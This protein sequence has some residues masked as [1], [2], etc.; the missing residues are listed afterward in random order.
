MPL[1]GNKVAEQDLRTWLQAHGWYGR[2]A[3]I[4]ELELVAIQRPGWVQVFRFR[5]AA[6]HQ[7]EGVWQD[8]RGLIRD[9]ERAADTR[10]TEVRLVS[11]DDEYAALFQDW[12]HGLCT[13]QRRDRSALEVALLVLFVIILA[14]AAIAAVLKNV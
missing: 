6:K 9:D 5:V 12:S 3:Q 8:L 7:T 14:L 4:Q 2:T 1:I 10:Q 11:T 13:V